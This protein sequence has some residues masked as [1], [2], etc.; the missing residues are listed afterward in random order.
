MAASMMF[1]CRGIT[2]DRTAG[3]CTVFVE[4]LWSLVV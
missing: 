1:L 3:C 2:K 4:F